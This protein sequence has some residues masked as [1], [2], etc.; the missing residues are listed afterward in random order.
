MDRPTRLVCVAAAALWAAGPAR[1]ASFDL[2]A[3]VRAALDGQTGAWVALRSPK[4]SHLAAGK[5]PQPVEV[6][7]LAAGPTFVS[8]NGPLDRA[9]RQQVTL[10]RLGLDVGVTYAQGPGHLRV[11]VAVANRGQADRGLVV[12]FGVPVDAVGWQ[13]WDDVQTPR[14][15][16]Q[17]S[18]YH[19]LHAIRNFAD[20]P[21]FR[22]RPATKLGY[23]SRNF[24]AAV[25]GPAGLALAYPLDQPRICRLTYDAQERLL[26]AAFDLALSPHTDP[27]NQAAVT[28]ELCACHGQWGLRSALS[29]YYQRHPEFFR[30]HV[31]REGQWMAF[32]DLEQID[33]V[34]EFG[35]QFQEGAQNPGYD[36]KLG[37]YSYTYFTHAGLYAWIPD[38]DPER[39]PKPSRERVMAAMTKRFDRDTKT[40]GT[41]Q[42][43]GLGQPDGALQ[44]W[45][46]T[47]YGHLIAQFNPDPDLLYGRHR[48]DHMDQVFERFRRRGGELDGFYYDG[49]PRGLN[50]RTDHFARAGFPPIW[51]PSQ[52]KPLLYNSFSSVEFAKETAKRLHAVGK[53]TMMNGAM[54]SSPFTAPYLDVMGAETGLR[55]SR[56]SFNYVR[57]ISRNKPFVTLLKGNFS[58]Y[59]HEHIESF[60]GRCAAYG[61]YPGFFDWSP[62]GLGPG[63]RYWDHGEWYERDRLLF[64]RYIPLV[65][66]LNRAGWDP[67]TYARHSSPQVQVERFGQPPG[68][69]YFT[70]L[71]DEALPAQGRLTVDA[72]ALGM[73][74][75]RV[76]VADELARA[77]LR[78]TVQGEGLVVPLALDPGQLVVVHAASRTEFAARQEAELI[79]I[80]ADRKHMAKLDQGRPERLL[81]WR[82]HRTTYS[83]ARVGGGNCLALDNTQKPSRRGAQQ[84]VML[85]QRNPKPIEI[86][87]RVKAQG[88][89]AGAGDAF[90]LRTTVCHVTRFTKRVR[91]TS[92]LPAGDHEWQ[93]VRIR[94]DP[95]RP[96]R[97]VLLEVWLNNVAGRAFID[98]VV[99][100][101]ADK[102]DVNY[103]VDSGMEEWYDQP[104][105]EVAARQ[106]QLMAALEAEVEQLAGSD[107]AATEAAVARALERAG[108][109]RAWI[110]DSGLAN[111]CRRALRDV[112]D[113]QSHLQLLISALAGLSGPTLAVSQPAIPG[114]SFEVAVRAECRGQ[115]ARLSHTKLD[116]PLGWGVDGKGPRFRVAVPASAPVGGTARLAVRAKVEVRP[117]V[118]TSLSQSRSVRIVKAMDAQLARWGA[119]DLRLRVRNNGA[120]PLRV[121]CRVAAPARWQA[122][123]EQSE[124]VCAAQAEHTQTLALRPSPAAPPGPQQVTV[125]L[126]PV[127][128][129]GEPCVL[130]AHVRHVPAHMNRLKNPGFEAVNADRPASWG[131]Y[132]DGCAV[133]D[134]IAHTGRRSLKLANP[135][136]AKRGASQTIALQQKLRCP[137]I[138][139][140][141]SKADQVRDTSQRDYSLYVDIYHTDGSAIYGRT[142]SFDLGTHD[143]QFA[144]RIIEPKKPIR[145]VNVYALHRRGRGTVWFDDV[146]VAELPSR[147]G[148]L[149]ADAAVQADSF[150]SKYRADPI[151]DGIAQVEGV[152][153]TDEA[154]ASAGSNKPHWI[155]LAFP[156]QVTVKR[157]AVYWSLDAGVPRTSERIAVQAKAGEQWRTV[158]EV[159]IGRVEPMTTVVL[160]RPVR[161]RAIRVWQPAGAGPKGRPQLMWVREV[162][163]FAE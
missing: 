21:E 13:W 125:T 154:W 108:A 48:L 54:S 94:I 84:W 64:R 33:N 53:H 96:M 71:N 124:F 141:W 122:K 115:A 27:P 51:D 129:P 11:T 56:P 69:C 30:K 143:W 73:D 40:K 120:R 35:F 57:M 67:L 17:G 121:R 61:V 138:V 26:Y 119:T 42:A 3:E 137:I 38:Y 95:D 82:A 31:E 19:N 132:T 148:N 118:W 50:Y 155:A 139:R 93:D 147:K 59:T 158:K 10:N 90:A 41:F 160:D 47:V 98:D 92:R 101:E 60:M 87:C 159:A 44:V 7:D 5:H 28:V 140:A 135:Q 116:A 36:D 20:L 66:E 74:V 111:P 29:A 91:Q 65:R 142:L 106:D 81:H 8:V 45:P 89:P 34:N 23:H 117:G 105:A 77:P 156:R 145:N 144:E 9:G 83:R 131:P 78:A 58:N 85:Y 149:A 80:M 4:G 113:C 32:S 107:S 49:L 130:S 162:E 2:G 24:V 114:Q 37:V 86:R 151:N 72:A 88:V 15:I 46:M 133:D 123:L 161:A 76:V 134:A 52:K 63:S 103:V 16:V 128:S 109:V 25:S 150:Y 75:G 14:Q 104:T 102:P 153:W 43:V 110:A 146:F 97:S 79:R 39:D 136:P 18:V 70:V 68:S 157:V 163:V 112:E 152:H 126:E 62:S 100:A 99:V 12:R 22:D 127:D 1:P 6:C 55:I